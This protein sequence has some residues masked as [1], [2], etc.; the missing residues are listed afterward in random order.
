MTEEI[1]IIVPINAQPEQRETV[2]QRL[3]DLAAKTNNEPGNICYVLHTVPDDPNQFIIYE[4]WKDQEALDF[5]MAQDYLKAFLADS[6]ALLSQEVKGT[7]C[8][9]MK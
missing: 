6:T 5:H 9:E 1:T 8:K 3:V 4:Q 2:H 7:I